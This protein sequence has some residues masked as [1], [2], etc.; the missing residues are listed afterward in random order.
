MPWTT[1]GSSER[2]LALPPDWDQRRRKCRD[3]AGGRCEHR[4]GNGG[5]CPEPG[6]DADHSG[7]R[8]DHDTLTW[9]CR[10]HHTM[11]TQQQSAAARRAILAKAKMPVERHP[12]LA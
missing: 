5:R 9:L 2:R 6:T 1:D 7:D 12:G 11:R 3:A 4:F 10:R 8:D